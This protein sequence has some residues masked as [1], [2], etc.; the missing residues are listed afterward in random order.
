MHRTRKYIA[1]LCAVLLLAGCVMGLLGAA[2]ARQAQVYFMAV[3]ETI[4]DLNAETIQHL[5]PP[6]CLH[7]LHLG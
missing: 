7:S 1:A 2:A 3:N 6:H 4:L 5:E